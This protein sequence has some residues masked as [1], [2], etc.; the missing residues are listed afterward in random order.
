MPYTPPKPRSPVASHKSSPALSRN[1]SY[2]K[3]PQSS[4]P[5]LPRSRSAAY[6]HKHRRSPALGDANNSHQNGVENSKS[7]ISFADGTSTVASAQPIY[8]GEGKP[9]LADTSSAPIEMG[10][11]DEED[12]GRSRQIAHLAETLKSTALL[13]GKRQHSPQREQNGTATVDANQSAPLMVDTTSGALTPEARKIAHSRS[14]S[15]MIP[16]PQSHQYLSVDTLFSPGDSDDEDDGLMMMGRMP[17]LRKKSGELVKPALRPSRS[18][19]RKRPCSAPG[20]PSYPKAVHFNENIEQVRH[21]LQVDRPSAVSANSSPVEVYESETDYPFIPDA[22]RKARPTVEW[23]IKT[24]FQ[25]DSHE[26]MCQPVRVEQIYLSK[27]MKSLE[28]VVAVAN[29]SFEKYVT[30]R[31][32][33]DYWKTTS[34]VGAEFSNVRYKGQPDGFDRFTFVIRL[35]DQAHLQ[36]KTLFMCVRYNSGGQEHWDSNGGQN[37]QV[38]FTRKLPQW[39]K[40]ETAKGAGGIPRSRNAGKNSIPRPRSFPVGSSDDE[41][42]TNFESPFR[43]KNRS[44][45]ERSQSSQSVHDATAQHHSGNRLANRYDFNTSLHTALLTAQHALGDKSGLNLNETVVPSAPAPQAAPAA[46]G[47]ARPT[48]GSA[49]YQALIQKFCYFGSPGNNNSV[50]TSPQGE[51]QEPMGL[52]IVEDTRADS[53]SE[54]KDSSA[55]SSASNSPPSPKAQLHHPQPLLDSKASTRTPSPSMRALSS[56]HLLPFRSPSPA[57]NPASAYQEFPHQGLS[58]QSAQC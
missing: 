18:S 22:A 48:L 11:S 10:S 24:N 32:T 2:E 46:A 3:S 54:S 52:G 9:S 23:E 27:D 7:S 6:I 25:P 51:A 31:F 21:F 56:P 39:T 28:G 45:L 57:L 13:M 29:I 47:G 34:E 40:P 50:L 41:F 30:A 43:L 26:R 53:S 44:M 14:S 20:T 36:N 37:Y 5:D 33:F 49:E 42:T 35:S 8:T 55:N 15:E 19:S 4:R 38:D 12:R 58:I 16:L 1:Q 17:L